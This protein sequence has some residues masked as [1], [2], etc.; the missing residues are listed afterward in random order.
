MLPGE[1]RGGVVYSEEVVP[2]DEGRKR[3]GGVNDL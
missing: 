3:A 2:S 1:G